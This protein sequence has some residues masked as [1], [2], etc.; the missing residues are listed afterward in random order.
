MIRKFFLRRLCFFSAMMMV[1]LLV[2]VLGVGAVMVTSQKN[3]LWMKGQDCLYSMETNIDLV[4][5]NAIYQYD[6]MTA[7]PRLVLSLKKLLG[8]DSF[9]YEDVIFLNSMRSILNSIASSHP[10][11]D[12]IYLY[13]DGGTNFL[14]STL[15]QVV[16][17]DTFDDTDW[18]DSYL[19]IPPDTRRAIEKRLLQRYSYW[20][21]DVI[22]IYQRMNYADGV[23]V[24]NISCDRFQEVLNSG[25]KYDQQDILLLNADG[26]LLA[27]NE[28]AKEWESM[29][30][31]GMFLPYLA[32]M[33]GEE[34][35]EELPQ[36]IRLDGK[37]YFLNVQWCDKYDIYLFSLIS[38]SVLYSMLK[39]FLW[40]AL[41]LLLGSLLITM[42]LAWFTTKRIFTQINDMITLFEQAEKGEELKLT[43]V[44]PKDEYDIIMNNIIL[45]YLRNSLTNT[46]LLERKLAQERA[47]M[48]ALQLQIN[49]HFLFNTLQTMDLEV[50]RQLGGTSRLHDMIR[51]LSGIL[52]YALS[53]SLTPV[54]LGEEI[55]YLKSYLNLHKMRFGQLFIAYFEVGEELAH[56][57]VFRLMLQPLV[58]NSIHHG[59]RPGMRSGFIKIKIY[60]RDEWLCFY[61]LD[62]GVGMSKG[63][64]RE[65]YERIN[66]SDSKNVGMTNVNRRLVLKYGSA[67]SLHIQSKQGYGSCISFKIPCS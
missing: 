8:R 26:R 4:V 53:S 33:R 63:R 3:Q 9:R 46:R 66:S 51:E 13:L 29:A 44:Q 41:A 61:V 17:L 10:Y 20:A 58:E 43:S 15:E 67:S 12:S 2:I 62:T 31:D 65:I 57:E 30:A 22:T 54:T 5:D 50:K 11:L 23:I 6:L 14:S 64:I 56:Y 47:E 59:L 28:R 24:V 32:W 34:I 60:K 45:M 16:T 49:P 27:A 38:G 1:P 19:S 40:I 55:E 35:G 39:P 36:V 7:N 37:K 21:Y 48:E 52:K 18:Y 25:R 42:S